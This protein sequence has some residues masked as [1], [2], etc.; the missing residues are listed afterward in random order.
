MSHMYKV[1]NNVLNLIEHVRMNGFTFAA[2]KG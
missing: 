2:Y 1:D